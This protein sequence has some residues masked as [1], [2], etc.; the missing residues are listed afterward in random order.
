MPVVNTN[1]PK[2]YDLATRKESTNNNHNHLVE[3]I[4]LIET[5]RDLKAGVSPYETLDQLR[6]E[7]HTLHTTPNPVPTQHFL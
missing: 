6:F 4:N 2:I 1:K 7:L 3:N 5:I